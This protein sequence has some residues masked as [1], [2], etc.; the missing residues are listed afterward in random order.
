MHQDV[1]QPNGGLQSFDM[2]EV[3][4]PGGDHQ[5]ERLSAGPWR[6]P[7]DARCDVTVDVQCEINDCLH[8]S[9]NRCSDDRLCAQSLSGQRR[10]LTEFGEQIALVRKPSLNDVGAWRHRDH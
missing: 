7:Q 2:V 8:H 10:Q 5:I 3:K 1:A 6:A 9:L 4:D